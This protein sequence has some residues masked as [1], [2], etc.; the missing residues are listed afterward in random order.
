VLGATGRATP[1]R[2]R[3]LE[4]RIRTWKDSGF[5]RCPSRQFA[6]NAAWL[7]LALIGI[8]LL[9]FTRILLLDGELALAEPKK[10]HIY[11]THPGAM[12][13]TLGGTIDPRRPADLA[14]VIIARWHGMDGARV[15]HHLGGQMRGLVSFLVSVV[16]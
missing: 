2:P 1:P 3:S 10:L 8:D 11:S 7:E 6:I 12:S 9:A 13:A 4:D 16:R 15:S 5:G 14:E